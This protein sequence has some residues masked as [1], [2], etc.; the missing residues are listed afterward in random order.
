MRRNKNNSESVK[1]RETTISLL[2]APLL[3]LAHPVADGSERLIHSLESHMHDWAMPLLSELYFR[4]ES[5]FAF[6]KRFY[7]F[8]N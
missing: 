6:H 4:N 2:L 5:F 1:I 3:R 7:G 8:F